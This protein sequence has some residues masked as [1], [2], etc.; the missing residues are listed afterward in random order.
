MVIPGPVIGQF[1]PYKKLQLDESRNESKEKREEKKRETGKST[2]I[3][4]HKS[5]VCILAVRKKYQ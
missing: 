1:R 4:N 2:Q 3:T 5:I